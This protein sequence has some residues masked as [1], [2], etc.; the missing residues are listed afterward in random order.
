MFAVCGPTP[1]FFLLCRYAPAY[2]Y[3]STS[4]PSGLSMASRRPGGPSKEQQMTDGSTAA[5]ARIVTVAAGPERTDRQVP[6]RD[7]RH[8]VLGGLIGKWINE[9]HTVA[10]RDIPS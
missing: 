10:T 3:L 2:L 1:L 5:K 7:R 9:G 8:E 4:S 6:V